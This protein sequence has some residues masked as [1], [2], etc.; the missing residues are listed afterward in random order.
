MFT[1]SPDMLNSFIL[2]VA[3]YNGIV[4]HCGYHLASHDLQRWGSFKATPIPEVIEGIR[5]MD[6]HVLSPLDG[7][8]NQIEG[9]AYV[10]AA[11]YKKFAITVA[12]ASSME[13]VREPERVAGV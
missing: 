5:A 1:D 8:I 11:G 13:M 9:A 12:D 4:Q 2:L 10:A 6:G 3:N 7:K